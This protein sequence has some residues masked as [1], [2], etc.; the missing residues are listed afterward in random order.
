M[1]KILSILLINFIILAEAED[2]SLTLYKYGTAM[3]RI[4][5]D[6]HHGGD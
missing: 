1:K 4:R 3:E 6:Y 2:A 5:D